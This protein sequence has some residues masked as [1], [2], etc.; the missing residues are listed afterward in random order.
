MFTVS[1]FK[2]DQSILDVRW[3]LQSDDPRGRFVDDIL[4]NG[5]MVCLWNPRLAKL[6]KSMQ[7]FMIVVLNTDNKANSEC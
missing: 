7:C 3:G 6:A 1:F 2:N 5:K 4:S